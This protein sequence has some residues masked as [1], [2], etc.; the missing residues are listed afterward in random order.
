MPRLFHFGLVKC[1]LTEAAAVVLLGLGLVYTPSDH[2]FPWP[3]SLVAIGAA[4]LIITSGSLPRHRVVG[5]LHTPI[6][7]SK[8]LLAHPWIVYVGKLSYPLYLWHWPTLVLFRHT[9]MLRTLRMRLIALCV[10]VLGA[11]FL[12]HVVEATFRKW[13]PRRKLLAPALLLFA[14]VCIFV[15]MKLLHGPFYGTLYPF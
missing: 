5:A 3:S 14:V 7:N 9:V 10:I 11:L 15:L 12:Y 1:L 13:R 4:L 2:A 8:H 6:L